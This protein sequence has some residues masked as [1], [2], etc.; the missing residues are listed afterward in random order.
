MDKFQPT[1]LVNLE[2]RTILCPRC[3]R[4]Q[5]MRDFATLGMNPLYATIL[6]TIYRCKLCNHLFAPRPVT[7]QQPAGMSACAN[8]SRASC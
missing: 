2:N 3:E 8:G 4:V 7:S 1:H 6:A 5:Q